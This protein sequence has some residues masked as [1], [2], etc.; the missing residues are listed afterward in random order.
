NFD[1]FDIGDLIDSS[2]NDDDRR[3]NYKINHQYFLKINNTTAVNGKFLSQLLH[4][5]SRKK[6][7]GYSLR[8]TFRHIGRLKTYHY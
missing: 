6:H 2:H 3:Y 5:S 1:C 4:S 8:K 7:R